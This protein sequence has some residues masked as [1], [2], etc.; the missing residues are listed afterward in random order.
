MA[1]HHQAPRAPPEPPAGCGALLRLGSRVGPRE[2]SGRS[3]AEG[4]GGGEPW[5]PQDPGRRRAGGSPRDRRQDA[6]ERD[7]R[8]GLQQ[9]LEPHGERKRQR[10]R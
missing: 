7:S 2:A 8:R 5:A 3:R 10:L 1:S 4:G 6:G 9:A